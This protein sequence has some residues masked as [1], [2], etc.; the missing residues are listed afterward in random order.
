VAFGFQSWLS[1][2][3]RSLTTIQREKGRWWCDREMERY[4]GGPT[5]ARK[6]ILRGSSQSE[7]TVEIYPLRL[8][9]HLTPKVDQSDIRMNIMETVGE[10]HRKACEIFG[11]ISLNQVMMSYMDTIYSMSM[12]TGSSERCNID[13]YG[14]D[15]DVGNML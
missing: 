10:L 12:I 15:D 14:C 7:L 3:E 5:L 13:V 11:L 1:L 9:F 8:Q 6:V 2:A 4:G